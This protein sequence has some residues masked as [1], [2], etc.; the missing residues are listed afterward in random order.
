M[1]PLCIAVS[2]TALLCSDSYC[3]HHNVVVIT[4]CCYHHCSIAASLLFCL[5][6]TV[7]LWFLLVQMLAHGCFYSL[8]PYQLSKGLF[9]AMADTTCCGQHGCQ[10]TNDGVA[11]V[12][13]QLHLS[14]LIAI[15]A[16]CQYAFTC[17][18]NVAAPLLFLLVDCCFSLLQNCCHIF[19]HQ[20]L[21]HSSCCQGG[22]PCLQC[23][24]YHHCITHAVGCCCMQ[25]SYF[26]SW[27][28]DVV[29]KFSSPVT[30]L[31]LWL[32]L[33]L[34]EASCCP[35]SSCCSLHHGDWT[36]CVLLPI[37]IIVTVTQEKFR[38]NYSINS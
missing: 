6:F 30:G 4:P 2:I 16:L 15:V 25:V 17:C 12:L 38:T 18:C 8:S 14:W 33:L 31:L 37:A 34:H 29:W 9:D 13:M 5:G 11:I 1:L 21:Y 28:I 26:C 35:Q 32:S 19:F 23:C 10:C 20:L 24:C 27:L 36:L 22:S 3:Q 7:L